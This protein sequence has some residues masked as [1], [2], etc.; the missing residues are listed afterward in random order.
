MIK[1]NGMKWRNFRD[2]F[3]LLL[4]FATITFACKQKPK[5]EQKEEPKEQLDVKLIEVQLQEQLQAF[6]EEEFSI[7]QIKKKDNSGITPDLHSAEFTWLQQPDVNF[8]V[9]FLCKENNAK[10]SK[11]RFM[12]AFE[13]AKQSPNEEE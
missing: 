8:T 3:L 2:S 4:L 11:S 12:D 7:Q 13:Q 9:R 5:E 6:T 1:W 10:L